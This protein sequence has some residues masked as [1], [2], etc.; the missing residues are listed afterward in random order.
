MYLCLGFDLKERLCSLGEILSFQSKPLFGKG[1][2]TIIIRVTIIITID[3]VA[4]V[5]ALVCVNYY[6]GMFVI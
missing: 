3:L 6:K 2:I 4:V 5:V 1:G